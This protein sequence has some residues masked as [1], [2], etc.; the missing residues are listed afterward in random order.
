MSL[1]LV[2]AS[3]CYCCDVNRCASAGTRKQTPVSLSFLHNYC[4]TS[5]YF[6]LYTPL[7]LLP[8]L[9]TLSMPR[10]S[11]LSTKQHQIGV[12]QSN[13]LT[14]SY[15]QLPAINATPSGK[16]IQK[17]DL[18]KE[19]SAQLLAMEKQYQMQQRKYHEL[20]NKILKIKSDAQ[21]AISQMPAG[22]QQDHVSPSFI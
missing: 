12:F 19:Q 14:N 22:Q 5:F 21:S 9:S 4:S 13:G 17:A 2:S 1:I 20:H 18:T 7:S 10:Q 6:Y 8:L 16:Q 3:F 15:N 11:S